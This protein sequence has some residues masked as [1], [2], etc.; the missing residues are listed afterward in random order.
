MNKSGRVVIPAS[1]DFALPFS[2]GLAPVCQGCRKVTQGE[3]TRYMGGN[4]GY[5]NKQGEMVIPAVYEQAAP[6]KQ[7]KDRVK[8]ED[9]AFLIDLPPT[10]SYLRGNYSLAVIYGPEHELHLPL[11]LL[12]Y[13]TEIAT[14]DK[15]SPFVHV[16]GIYCTPAGDYLE[17][18]CRF[19][20]KIGL[21]WQIQFTTEPLLSENRAVFTLLIVQEQRVKY[22]FDFA[23]RGKPG[24]NPEN[25]PENKKQTTPFFWQAMELIYFIQNEKSRSFASRVLKIDAASGLS[26]PPEPQPKIE[27]HESFFMSMKGLRAGTDLRSFP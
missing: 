15:Q 11:P 10:E 5:T 18:L 2:Q 3:H 8:R 20:D 24:D 17:G 25:N 6:F 1:F 14:L 9:Q 23:Y 22:Q 4:W 12:P 16:D 19:R 21:P 13:K 26:A 7:G 27:N